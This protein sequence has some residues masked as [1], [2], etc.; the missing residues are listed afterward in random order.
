MQNHIHE[1]VAGG[2]LDQ[3]RVYRTLVVLKDAVEFD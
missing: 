3:P 1:A 2:G